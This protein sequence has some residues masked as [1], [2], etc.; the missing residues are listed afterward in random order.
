M[1]IKNIATYV[2]ILVVGLIVG[3]FAFHANVSTVGLGPVSPTS[4][5]SNL[6]ASEVIATPLIQWIAFVNQVAVVQKSSTVTSGSCALGTSTMFDVANPFNGNSAN[7][8]IATST[9]KLSIMYVQST[10]QAT[11]T[12]FSVGTTTLAS[13]V[14]SAATL[15]GSLVN[16][17]LV[18]T[19]TQATFT[20][21]MSTFLGSGQISAGTSV[22]TVIVAPGER[23]AGYATST[24]GTSGAINYVPGIPCTYEI[25]WD[26]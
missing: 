22:G 7:F 23:V 12:T 16:A 25:Q 24:Y 3:W 5:V 18:A 15:G 14:P 1:N 6:Q 17:G 10:G 4:N 2:G 26:N 8:P 20:S 19:G 9:A 13:G 21:G 11:S